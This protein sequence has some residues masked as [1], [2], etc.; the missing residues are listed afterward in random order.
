MTKGRFRISCRR[1]RFEES[2]MNKP[3]KSAR[4]STADRVLGLG[5]CFLVP[6]ALTLTG[7]VRTRLEGAGAAQRRVRVVTCVEAVTG[8]LEATIDARHGAVAGLANPLDGSR[9]SGP[10]A[11]AC[12]GLGADITER[13]ARLALQVAAADSSDQRAETW[14]TAIR[15][16]Q[17][18]LLAVAEAGGLRFEK[19]LSTYYLQDILV[20]QYPV[21]VDQG[22]RVGDAT[23]HDAQGVAPEL[24][25][26]RSAASAVRADLRRLADTTTD[27]DIA[28]VATQWGSTYENTNLSTP[29]Q[30]RLR[31][32][33]G[34][35]LNRAS[36]SQFRSIIVD[37]LQNH[38]RAQRSS[39]NRRSLATMLLSLVVAAALVV[40]LT[41]FTTRLRRRIAAAADSLHAAAGGDFSR[42]LPVERV[43]DFGS[44]EEGINRTVGRLG[45]AE[46][47]LRGGAARDATTGLLNRKEF[48]RSLATMIADQPRDEIVGVTVVDLGN[49]EFVNDSYGERRGDEVL[50]AVAARLIEHAGPTAAVGRLGGVAFGVIQSHRRPGEIE[51]CSKRVMVALES[52][53]TLA[54]EPGHVELD[55]PRA[56]L[57][58]RT[59]DQLLG[60]DQLL[61]DGETAVRVARERGESL[62][63]FDAE[64]RRAARRRSEIRA[65]FRNPGGP[66]SAGFYLQFAPCVEAA[67]GQV[68]EFAA[69]LR[70][71]H[72]RFGEV[73][74]GEFYELAESVEAF[75]ELTLFVLTEAISRVAAWR[76]DQPELRV[77]VPLHRLQVIEPL[78]STVLGLLAA[79]RLSPSCL[80]IGIGADDLHRLDLTGVRV[81]QEIGD[82]GIAIIIEGATSGFMSPQDLTL[83]S[84]S[85]I[86]IDERIIAALGSP[87]DND[88]S[89]GDGA[90]VQ[91][92]G[93]GRAAAAM[94]GALVRFAHELDLRAIA[95]G[96]TTTPQLQAAF[97]LGCDAFSGPLAG[98]FVDAETAGALVSE[99][100]V[101]SPNPDSDSAADRSLTVGDAT[102]K[103]SETEPA[104]V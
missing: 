85:A 55:A 87:E 14:T 33:H 34:P 50:R 64:M 42:N 73:S 47:Q 92:K 48:L 44:I 89:E 6:L 101:E 52:P 67:S 91:L 79:H 61:E 43:D 97:R 93:A 40:M 30:I 35:N 16:L 12:R 84:P 28:A 39:A 21:L 81:L 58:L 82:H 88:A 17:V 63:V 60:A 104:T 24:E 99:T 22:A 68:S 9:M 53:F 98:G 70:W 10:A 83:I 54:D 51:S 26:L 37:R 96:V 57:A 20:T 18:H 74:A 62:C 13:T 72:P 29:E 77:R 78:P 32:L 94:V 15:S 46:A 65:E 95:E 8:L 56:G 7:F 80:S 3:K 103:P 75:D 59:S 86:T 38:V 90:E 19:D 102:A 2:A 100:E 11:Q 71:W 76:E 23:V 69:A 49:L 1:R 27:P 4:L 66:Q 25:V 5:L 45:E 31:A 36:L 41:R